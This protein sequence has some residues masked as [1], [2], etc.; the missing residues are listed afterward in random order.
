MKKCFLLILH[1]FLYKKARQYN[2][3]KN[4]CVHCIDDFFVQDYLKHKNQKKIHSATVWLWPELELLILQMFKKKRFFGGFSH[5]NNSKNKYFDF[6]L[7]PAVLT[8]VIKIWY[9]FREDWFNSFEKSFNA[10][11][12]NVVSRKTRLKFF[13]NENLT[14]ILLTA[15]QRYLHHTE[16]FLPLRK[17]RLF[18]FDV[19]KL[20]TWDNP[21]NVEIKLRW[22][23][24]N[25][26][27]SVHSITLIIEQKGCKLKDANP[28]FHIVSSKQPFTNLPLQKS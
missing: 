16:Y 3:S 18:K 22:I 11:S 2:I 6:I 25:N 24:K 10:A 1:T 9:K 15:N 17:S 7:V 4:R 19:F 21:L 26:I 23:K 27:F 12:K 8:Y 13:F 5:Q 20:I 14:K 28:T